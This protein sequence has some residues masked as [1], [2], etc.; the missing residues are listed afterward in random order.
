MLKRHG[1]RCRLMDKR[2]AI[3]TQDTFNDIG[4]SLKKSKSLMFIVNYE[5]PTVAVLRLVE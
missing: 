3:H 5:P 2:E 1:I 4:I